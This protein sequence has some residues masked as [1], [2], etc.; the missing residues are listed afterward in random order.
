MTDRAD[1]SACRP[2]PRSAGGS[3]ERTWRNVGYVVFGIVV[4]NLAMVVGLNVLV[5][6]LEVPTLAAWAIAFGTHLFV[7]SG[8]GVVFT[9]GYRLFEMAGALRLDLGSAAVWMIAA[10]FFGTFVG[11][12]RYR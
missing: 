12:G 4:W 2:T 7:R 11:I 5:G 8:V 10:W 1:R 6:W 9:F 3:G